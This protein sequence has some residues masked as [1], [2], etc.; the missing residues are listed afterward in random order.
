M[1]RC[2]HTVLLMLLC[3]GVTWTDSAQAA[4][5]KRPNVIFILVD[6]MGWSDLGCYGGEIATPNLDSLAR[7]GM[8]FLGCHNTAKC[9]PSRACLLSGLYAQ[10]TGMDRDF[11]AMR[12]C[13]TLGEALRPAGYHTYAVG[14][15][16]CRENLYDRGFDHYYGLRDGCCNFFNPGDQRDGEGEPA[17]KRK[18]AWCFDEKTLHPYTPKEKDFYTTDYFTKWAIQFL[19]EQK[20][21]D[22]PF[23]LYLAYTAPHYPLHAW[24]EDIA[25]YKGKYDAGYGAIRRARYTRQKKMGLIDERYPL[26]P[27][28]HPDW[29]SLNDKKRA[30]EIKRMEV[31]AAMVDRLDQNIGQLLDWLKANGEYE[32]TLIFFASDNGACAEHLNFGSGEIGTLT[33]YETVGRN[34]ANVSNTPLRRYKADS[35][36]GGI[37]TPLI[38]HWP[39]GPIKPGRVDDT[40]YCHFIDI[41][42][43]ICQVAEATY[44]QQDNGRTVLPVEGVSLLPAL[45]GEK[46]NRKKPLFFQWGRGRAVIHDGWKLVAHGKGSWEL[47]HLDQDR[48]ETNNLA[49][50]E[51]QRVE[52]M[53]AMYDQWKARCAEQAEAE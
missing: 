24:P 35:Y 43:T 14:K 42:P 18:R 17:R 44:P 53:A 41:L 31:Y 4:P 32:N 38:A 27:A 5:D 22:K 36:Q 3:L 13:V 30:M 21:D 48:T 29:N 19:D 2:M 16:H 45:R 51:P 34:W 47:Y 8:R 28:E 40:T 49:E 15:H 1:N 12:N 26:P 23:L 11:N 9:F 46:L 39:A 50:K 37:N 6:D 10:Q 52:R 25:K 7:G 20:N 33:R